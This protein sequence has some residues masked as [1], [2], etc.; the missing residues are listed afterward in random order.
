MKRIRQLHLPLLLTIAAFVGWYLVFAPTTIGGPA[1]YVWVSGTSME[2]TL[3]GGDFVIL[4]RSEA[5]AVGDI[6]AYRVPSGEPGA[7]ILVIHR[8]IG[9]SAAD[10]FV[11]QGDN[12]SQPD[13]WRPTPSDIVGS[14][15]LSVA[16][17]SKYVGMLRAP[18][19]VGS[20]AA[21]LVV[22]MIMAGGGTRS[23]AGSRVISTFM[24]RLRP[25]R[26]SRATPRAQDGG[27]S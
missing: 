8:I 17:G 20:L 10:G 15:W 23:A 1:S 16:G 26:I 4:R 13:P 3:V 14:Q 27:G 22:F 21:G 2:P 5:Y 7:G 24:R 12:K 18:A 19:V 11:M 25:A 9:G 6:V